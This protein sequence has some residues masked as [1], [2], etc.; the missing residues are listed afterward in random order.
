MVVGNITSMG[1]VTS[2]TRVGAFTESKTSG[3]GAWEGWGVSTLITETRP[4]TSVWVIFSSLVWWFNYQVDFKGC[5]T[6]TCSY[7]R[8]THRHS[9]ESAKSVFWIIFPKR[10]LVIE[11]IIIGK[12]YLCFILYKI[13]K[14]KKLTLIFC[15]GI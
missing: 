15:L 5:I 13:K 8:T 7:A 10:L 14:K 6:T 9:L 3:V 1:K 12:F 2:L 11:V 4:R